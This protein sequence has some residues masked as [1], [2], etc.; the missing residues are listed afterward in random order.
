MHVNEAHEEYCT[1]MHCFHNRLSEE[2][3]S[4]AKCIVHILKIQFR[5]EVPVVSFYIICEP[6]HGK[7]R[8]C[9]GENKGV[10]AKLISAFVFAK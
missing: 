7:P 1:K 6:P 4:V 2:H 3:L 5:C 9:K 8:I 10:T